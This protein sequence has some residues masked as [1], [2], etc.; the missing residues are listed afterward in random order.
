M[1]TLIVKEVIFVHLYT[2]EISNS[3]LK[4]DLDFNTKCKFEMELEVLVTTSNCMMYVYY[5]TISNKR[6]F[7]FQ[8]NVIFLL[9]VYLH[10]VVNF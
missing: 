1:H 7:D 8:N 3:I 9:T 6:Y 4:Y 5:T 2:R 10:S